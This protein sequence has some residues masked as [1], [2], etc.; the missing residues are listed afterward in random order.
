MVNKKVNNTCKFLQTVTKCPL[1]SKGSINLHHHPEKKTE[2]WH[3]IY[4]HA[5]GQ[6]KYINPQL[7]HSSQDNFM[8]P[9]F[10]SA[11]LHAKV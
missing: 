9:V 5:E 11:T 10:L 1:Y 8:T 4:S 7:Q 3:F 2:K 6:N